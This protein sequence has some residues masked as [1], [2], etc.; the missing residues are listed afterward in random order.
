VTFGLAVRKLVSGFQ[1]LGC[2]LVRG[3]AVQH[4]SSPAV[5]GGIK[6]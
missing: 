2:D 3:L 1:V 5:V 6:S 4:A